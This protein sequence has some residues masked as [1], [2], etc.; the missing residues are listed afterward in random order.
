MATTIDLPGR[1]SDLD[2]PAV[3]T[4]P[5][6]SQSC[7]HHLINPNAATSSPP[8]AFPITPHDV[9]EPEGSLDKSIDPLDSKAILSPPLT[10]IDSDYNPRSTLPIDH[11]TNSNGSVLTSPLPQSPAPPPH[12]TA[13]VRSSPSIAPSDPKPPL[14]PTNAPQLMNAPSSVLSEAS[15]DLDPSEHPDHPSK[16]ERPAEFVVEGIGITSPG[17]QGLSRASSI[18]APDHSPGGQPAAIDSLRLSTVVLEKGSSL[19]HRSTPSNPDKNPVAFNPVSHDSLDHSSTLSSTHTAA[20]PPISELG[21]ASPVNYSAASKEALTTTSPSHSD[22][23]EALDDPSGL[24]HPPDALEPVP[25]ANSNNSLSPLSDVP[26]GLSPS[27]VLESPSNGRSPK[28]VLS[29]RTSPASFKRQSS[30]SFLGNG[31]SPRADVASF[32][33]NGSTSDPHRHNAN[34]RPRLANDLPSNS[35]PNHTNSIP[36]PALPSTDLRQSTHARPAAGCHPSQSMTEG[37]GFIPGSP[38]T[39][40]TK[41]QQR[42]AI[43]V[44][45]QLKKHRSAG[46]FLVPVDPV[47]LRIPDYTAVIKQPM[48]LSTIEHRLG[49]VG[50]SC[51]YRSVE[52]FVS[53]VQL[54]FSNCYTYNGPPVTSPYSRMALDLSIQFETQMKKMPPDEPLSHAS[55]SRSPSL[56][57]PSPK[58]KLPTDAHSTQSTYLK[59]IASPMASSS[60]LSAVNTLGNNKRRSSS[61]QHPRKKSLKS[62]SAS[63]SA[64]A[65]VDSS[66]AHSHRRASV[67][68]PSYSQRPKTEV[69]GQ[70]PHGGAQ[71]GTVASESSYIPNT[72]A[73]LK[74]CKEVLREF[75]K[76]AHE[77][78]AWPFYQ[79]VDIVKLGIPDYPKYVKRPMDMATMNQKLK[80]G[81]YKDGSAFAEDF[82]LMLSNCFVYNPVGSVYHDLGKKLE[83]VFEA[84]WAERPPDLIHAPVVSQAPLE[85]SLDPIQAL[86]MQVAQLRERLDAT[87]RKPRANSNH[88]VSG[89]GPSKKQPAARAS[90]SQKNQANTSPHAPLAS[91]IPTSV[92]PDISKPNGMAPGKTKQGHGGARRKSGGTALSASNKQQVAPPGQPLTER[93]PDHPQPPQPIY[94]AP[95]LGDTNYPSSVAVSPPVV[96]RRVSPVDYFEKID[97]EQ[98]K[99]LATQIQNAVEPM[100]SNA[101]NLIRNSRPDLV[102]AD[103]EEIELDIDALDDRTLYQLYQLVC[104]PPPAAPPKVKKIKASANGKSKG[105]RKPGNGGPRKSA[106]QAPPYPMPT[107]QPPAVHHPQLASS[108]PYPNSQH[109]NGHGNGVKSKAKKPR[110]NPS[111]P[112]RKGIDETQEAARIRELEEKLHVFQGVT[113]P[114]P[115]PA[116]HTNGASPVNPPPGSALSAPPPAGP[117]EYASSS[118]E[119]ESESDDESD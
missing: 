105:G 13:G 91:P 58:T 18:S 109:S 103:G 41:D 35:S 93:Q 86:Q 72:K 17:E 61:P 55:T 23:A 20:N 14:T 33:V 12:V 68:D 115:Q 3:T 73:E 95:P 39:R 15:S 83:S 48:D 62:T 97:Y 87:T 94:Q 114:H 117:V 64:P 37:P 116:Y 76:K 34:K 40:F 89:T 65:D 101:I 53:D 2:C 4:S 38:G 100:Q 42:F 30:P 74:F 9:P 44:T 32:H 59:K 119:S 60:T 11:H 46:P 67:L 70:Y 110:A 102:A 7:A 57:K 98:K 77:S 85:T 24:A 79:P 49:K 6:D 50:K 19:S 54:I 69:Q 92:I 29:P 43:S 107:P 112:K 104:A 25:I 113:D 51:Y 88:I 47:A 111:L 78:Y 108:W 75:N 80:D 81:Q 71:Y 22:L 10:V 66:H 96:T 63:A 31:T 84:K 52:D 99:D 1:S 28:S 26:S 56:V 90:V 36:Q 5:I 118:S 106:N 45:K 8:Q 16:Q 82:R 27:H 21:K